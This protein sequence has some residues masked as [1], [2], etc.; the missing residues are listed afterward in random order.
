[1]NDY[2]NLSADIDTDYERFSVEGDGFN[3]DIRPNFS[4]FNKVGI[5]YRALSIFLTFTPPLGANQDENLKGKTELGGFGFSFNTDK[6]INHF[7][8][9]K[10]EGFYLEN[11]DEFIPEFVEG[12]SAYIQ[13][14]GLAYKSYRGTHYY[15]FNRNFSYTAFTVQMARQVKSQGSF[16]TGLSW[17]YYS[18]NNDNPNAQDTRNL[19]LLYDAA[20]YYTYVIDSKW[21]FN[22]GA[23]LGFGT[24]ITELTTPINGDEII[25]DYNTFKMRGKGYLGLGYNSDKLYFGT[26]FRYHHLEQNQ[27][28]GSAHEEL[29]GAFFRVFIGLHIKAP[30]FINQTYDKVEGYFGM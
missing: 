25:T 27:P 30:R 26:D 1:M 2:F 22:I 12:S 19:E 21:Y 23:I 14:P 28:Q 15:K 3:Y 20:Y 24:T 10:T 13:F 16:A 4:Y 8:Y 5:D 6:L 7:K 9:T 17:N 18:V 29:T 11:S